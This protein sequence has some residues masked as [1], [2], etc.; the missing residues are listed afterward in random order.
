MGW[1]VDFVSF[2]YDVAEFI[3]SNI[4]QGQLFPF[5]VCLTV[6][7]DQLSTEWSKSAE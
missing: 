3:A 1:M 5:R 2:S 4:L 7:G 6:K